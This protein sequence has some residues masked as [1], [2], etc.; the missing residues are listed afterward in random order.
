MDREEIGRRATKLEAAGKYRTLLNRGKFT[1]GWQPNW[2][3]TLCTIANVDFD[4]V[5]DIVGQTSFTK[6][7]LPVSAATEV[8]PARQ[9]ERGGNVETTNRSRTVLQPFANEFFFG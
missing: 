2:P 1:R 6:Q 9:I 4:K 8:G 5:K 7:V 3:D